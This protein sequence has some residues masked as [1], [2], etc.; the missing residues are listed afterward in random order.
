MVELQGYDTI[1]FQ[2]LS[3]GT[4]GEFC[5]ALERNKIMLIYNG[6]VHTMETPPLTSGFVALRE[7]RIWAVGPMEL[8]PADWDG[9]TL[10]AQGGHILPGFVDAHCHLGMF[11]D[12]LGLEG[13]DGNEATDPCTPHLRAVDAVNPLDRCFADARIGGVTTVFTGPGSAN[14]I[15][16]QFAAIKTNGR[17][18]DDMVLSAPAAMKLALGENPKTP[19]HERREG[20]TTRMA[21]AAI[22]REHLMKAVEYRDKLERAERDEEEDKPDFDAKLHALLPVVRGALPVHIH[23]HRADDIA[24]GIRICHEFGL[25]YVIVHGTEGHLISDLLA[26]E[27]AAVITGPCLGDR[28]KPELANMTLENPAKLLQAGV[29]VAVCTDHPETPIQ[30][31]PLCAAMAVRGGMDPE[32]ALCAITLWAA[33]IAGVS[34][35]V[36]SLSLGKDGDVVVTGGHPLNWMSRV[37]AVFIDG[38]RVR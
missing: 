1:K 20:P 29:K 17:W 2:F 33:E 37:N 22:I 12:S 24:T 7:G 13:D 11:G 5:L 16:G 32:S 15:S 35:R 9:E 26:K 6:T 30:H 8:C 28:S 4:F 23:A 10:D 34:D 18:I 27:K 25:R 14:P 36:G 19:Y 3:M 31:L 38:I 21:T